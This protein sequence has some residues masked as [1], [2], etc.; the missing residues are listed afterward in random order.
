MGNEVLEEV[1][2][3]KARLKIAELI[4]TRPRTLKELSDITGISVQGVLKHLGRLRQLGLVAESRV[5]AGTLPVRKLYS[6]K[7][8]RIGDFSYGDLTVVKLT[9]SSPRGAA[10][11]EGAREMEAL[12]GDALV[13]RRRI[14][15]QARKLAR[16]IDELFETE[17][18]L[19]RIIRSLGLKD[20]ERL[21]VQTAFTE[22]SIEEAEKALRRHHGL[23]EAR[24]S[25]ERAVA[26]ARRIGKK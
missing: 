17:T 13:Q 15:E 3:S 10:P 16:L 22:E 7:D 23:R 21:I 5:A 26:K 19:D 8:V 4:S 14:R 6:T 2:S 25:L 20:D 24:V 9:K 1:T 12:A 11:T 18:R